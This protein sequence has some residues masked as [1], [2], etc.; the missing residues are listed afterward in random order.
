MNCNL[1]NAEVIIEHHLKGLWETK[2]QKNVIPPI[3][4][5]GPPGI[6]KSH[7]IETICQKHNIG[8]ID[9]R[10]SQREPVDMRGLPV[11]I[12]EQEKVKWLLNSEYPCDPN[13]KGIIFFDE[14]TACDRTL[15]VAAYEFILDRRLGDSYKVPDGWYICAAGNGSNDRAVYTRLSSSL[16]NRF[17]HLEIEPNLKT[18]IIWALNN[19]I[20][21]III[22]FLRFKPNLFF[23]MSV[24]IQRG[25]PSPR[26]WERVSVELFL[27][28]KLELNKFELDIIIT[29]LVGKGA[30]I[31]LEAYISWADKLPDVEKML[32]GEI[33]VEIPKRADQRY[34]LCA[35]LVH[36][37]VCSSN[38]ENIVDNFL[39]ILVQMTSDFAMLA[40]TDILK[41][42]DDDKAED[43]I[44]AIF[45]SK[46]FERFQRKHGAI[47]R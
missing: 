12:L 34:A 8:F 18:W 47:L 43:R 7:I 31:E 37:F 20:H 38:S 46:S 6:G 44:T 30:G 23:D 27:A 24:D 1:K 33:N 42:I 25:W 3:L 22:S 40:M 2:T 21:P 11:P 14:L 45:S 39:D 26:S 15:Q 41:H 28:E 10:L 9:I 32:L 17:C 29:G 4:M 16:A 19:N 36:Y 35:A 5:T 13:S